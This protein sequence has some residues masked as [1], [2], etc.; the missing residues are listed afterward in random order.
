LRSRPT[1]SSRPPRFSSPPV[2]PSRRP[3]ASASLFPQASSPTS[4]GH[5][6]VSSLA[7]LLC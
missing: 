1:S 7:S 3:Q 4:S 6:L 5:V 2:R